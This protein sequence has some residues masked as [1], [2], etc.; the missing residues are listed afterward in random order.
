MSPPKLTINFKTNRRQISSPE[1]PPDTWVRPITIFGYEFGVEI[2][3]RSS[4]DYPHQLK[5]ELFAIGD[6]VDGNNY[7]LLDHQECSFTLSAENKRTFLFKGD[8]VK[9]IT[10]GLYP[11]S[12]LIGVKY[13]GHLVVVTDVQRNIIQHSETRD[14]LFENLEALKQVPVGKHFDKN[15]NRVGPP[16]L[17][18]Y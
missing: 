14:F 10:K 4:S 9:T 11:E 8:K 18:R 13:S 7:V 15:C 1:Q 6:E 2:S 12:D 3:Q 17:R 16:R 5:A